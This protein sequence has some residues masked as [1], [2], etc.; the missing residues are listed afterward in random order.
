MDSM[1]ELELMNEKIKERCR[2]LNA[3]IRE[4]SECKGCGAVVRDASLL[5]PD[6]L[7]RGRFRA[8]CP[9]CMK[10]E[11]RSTFPPGELKNLFGMIAESVERPV[12]VLVLCRTVFEVL[13]DGL[14]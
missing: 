11:M 12:I 4:Y 9:S 5:I 6:E 1:V 13:I 10:E 2:E 7:N 8:V 14:L 3:V